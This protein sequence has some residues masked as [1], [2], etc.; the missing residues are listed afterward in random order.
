ML[1]FPTAFLIFLLFILSLP[2]LFLL[3]Y[4]HI[5]TL[6]FEKLGIPPEGTIFLLFLI[7][8]GSGFNIP[9]TK[10]KLIYTIERRFF[11]LFQTPT[12]K[13]QC[14]AI[15]L[16]GAIIPLLLSFYFLYSLWQRRIN[17]IPLCLAIILMIIVCKFLAR[18]IPG[19]GISLPALIPSVFSAIFSL[20]LMPEFAA[21]S[22][23]ISG[24]LGVLIGG[25]LLNLKRIQKLSPGFISIGGAGVFD[26]IFLVAILSALLS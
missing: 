9:L 11:G 20:I 17:L 21:P 16:G 5:I 7:L 8:I 25:D 23:F 10:K 14:L 13:I 18:V 1:F 22:A 26:G 4:F 3:A 12:L 2:I 19:K 15:N 6:G 24:V